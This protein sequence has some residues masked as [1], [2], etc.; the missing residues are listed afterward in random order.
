MHQLKRT[1][2]LRDMVV[3]GLLFIGPAAPVGL[4]GTLEASSQGLTPLVYLI[5]TLVMAFTA[6]S[7]SVMSS[8]IPNAGAVYAYASRGL[9]PAAGFIAGWV[10]LLDYLFIPAVAYLFSGISLNALFPVLPVWFW[11]LLAVAV[12]TGLNVI[13]LQRARKVS[14]L[15][16][17]AEVA[18]LLMIL[19][20]GAWVVWHK[21]SSVPLMQ[22][23]TGSQGVDI[24]LLLSSVSVALL[25][26]LGFDAI[27]SFGEE[28]HGD[29]RQTGRA[30]LI[31]LFLAGGLFIAQTWLASLLSPWSSH[32]LTEHPGM[33][34]KAYYSIVS[35]SVAGWLGD[36]L[37]IVKAF[38]AAFSAMIGQ[39]AAGRLLFSLSRDR[40][41]PSAL[42]RVSQSNGLPVVSILLAA[43]VNSLLAVV[44]ALVPEG[45]SHL[46][47]FVDVGA[48]C[49]FVFLHL[50]V[51]GWMLVKQKKRGLRNILL[52]GL[53]PVAGLLMLLPVL[54]SMH[55][56]ALGIAAVWLVIG[57]FIYGFR[58]GHQQLFRV[59]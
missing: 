4:Y 51:T 36:L 53:L 11:T 12:T 35:Q 32:W 22:P 14:L 37:A 56:F 13:G 29:R 7:Y 9:S 39:A 48:I 5:A 27:S 46:V 34:G 31:C 44:A 55:A 21:G 20:G 54:F 47:S 52:Y 15:V 1:L 45:L 30:T 49:G 24:D 26:F 6:W 8:E 19:A 23:I 25:S 41:L 58:R 3:M 2:R 16:V 18:V 28:N 43:G 59:L 10:I 38:G 42:S 50:S 57:L 33:Q 17:S 40:I